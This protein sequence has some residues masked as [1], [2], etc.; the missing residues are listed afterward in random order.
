MSGLI[1]SFFLCSFEQAKKKNTKQKR[2]SLRAKTQRTARKQCCAAVPGVEGGCCDRLVGRKTGL[3]SVCANTFSLPTC[4]I[5]QLDQS[6]RASNYDAPLSLPER[7]ARVGI[8]CQECKHPK[9][10]FQKESFTTKR[11][12]LPLLSSLI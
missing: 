12:A 11:F 5:Q 4:S 8:C 3:M 7:F 9:K 6:P 10:N 2:N 1:S